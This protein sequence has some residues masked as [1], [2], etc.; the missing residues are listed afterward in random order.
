[1][2]KTKDPEIKPDEVVPDT[3]PATDKIECDMN[4]ADKVSEVFEQAELIEKA[5]AEVTKVVKQAGDVLLQ[6]LGNVNFEFKGDGS[7]VTK[8]DIKAQEL[9]KNHLN[10]AFPEFSFLGEEGENSETEKSDFEWVVDPLDGTI[11][12]GNDIDFF[13]ISVGLKYK[14]TPVLGVVYLPAQKELLTGD[15][16]G[17]SRFN[18]AEIKKSSEK[19]P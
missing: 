3:D 12:F 16:A 2:D 14:N 5:K 18:D 7:H 4:V 10:N 9:I 13:A 19:K 8:A 6:F 17:K 11:N 1:M 15:V